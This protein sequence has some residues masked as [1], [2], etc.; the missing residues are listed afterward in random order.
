MPALDTGSWSPARL[1]CDNA[2]NFESKVLKHLCKVS[3]IKKVSK[4]AKI[5][6]RYN[7][8]PQLT[9]DTNGK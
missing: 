2:Q 3:V 6:N 9:Q 5:R 4:G 8:V 1:R 7:Q